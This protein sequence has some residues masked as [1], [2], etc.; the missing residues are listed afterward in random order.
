ML[1]S[2]VIPAY[3][4]ERLLGATLEQIQ[5]ARV[6]FS[7][8]GWQTEIIV[9]NNNS[10]DRTAEVA[11][12]AGARVVFEPQNQIARARNCG[13]AAAS[14]EWLVFVDADSHPSR[15]LFADTA[16]MIASGKYLAG[17]STVKLDAHCP[18][19]RW[20]LMFW[21]TLSRTFRLMAGSYIFCE[22]AAFREVGG[23]SNELFVTEELDLTKKLK[24]AARKRRRKIVIL[25]RHPLVTSGRK[26]TL[27]RP[28]EHVGFFLRAM[29]RPKVLTRR[30]ECNIWYD[31]RR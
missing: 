25:T 21:N 1:I 9:C 30:E 26:M 28:V 24:K 27:Y 10:T 17:G 11:A 16:E 19:A 5:R 4:E 12:A 15:E 20:A 6:A 18:R 29:L 31:G 23:F 7:E 14:G 2:I 22:T 13:A 3:N 8:R